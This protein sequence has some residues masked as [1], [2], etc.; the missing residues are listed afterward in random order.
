M[1]IYVW[2]ITKLI[3]DL[4]S[5]YNLQD[6][7]EDRYI[8]NVVLTFQTFLLRMPIWKKN[9]KNSFTPSQSTLKIGPKTARAWEG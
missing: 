1:R 9:Q 3:F 7:L 6:L 5:E 2:E 8:V 4:G